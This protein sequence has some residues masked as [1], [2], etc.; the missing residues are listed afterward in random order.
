MFDY[1][2]ISTYKRP[3]DL[4]Q[5]KMEEDRIEDS[6]RKPERALHVIST[7]IPFVPLFCHRKTTVIDS[8]DNDTPRRRHIQLV[9]F[10]ITCTHPDGIR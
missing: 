1:S 9:P 4:N 2:G 3:L 10:V 5:S 7:V 8:E 6:H